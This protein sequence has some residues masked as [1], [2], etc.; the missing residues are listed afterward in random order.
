MAE[1]GNQEGSEERLKRALN[2]A[3]PVCSHF[4]PGSPGGSN[5]TLKELGNYNCVGGCGCWWLKRIR[6]LDAQE[7]FS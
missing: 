6:S 4:L 1:D 5:T 2:S 3:A 7:I